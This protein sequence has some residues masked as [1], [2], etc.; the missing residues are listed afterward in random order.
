MKLLRCKIAPHYKLKCYTITGDSYIIHTFEAGGKMIDLKVSFLPQRRRDAE[1][2][3]RRD[4]EVI[5][6]QE[7]HN[8]FIFLCAS[9]SLRLLVFAVKKWNV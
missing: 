3:N 9:A 6:T 1:M 2:D 5:R 4:A 8:R 7:I